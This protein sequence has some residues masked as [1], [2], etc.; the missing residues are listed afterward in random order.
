MQRITKFKRFLHLRPPYWIRH[1]EFWSFEFRFVII[2]L[3]NLDI[4]IF[5][6]KYFLAILGTFWR[7]LSANEGVKHNRLFSPFTKY[8]SSLLVSY[9]VV[10]FSSTSFI[11]CPRIGSNFCSYVKFCSRLRRFDDGLLAKACKIILPSLWAILAAFSCSG[12]RLKVSAT[13]LFLPGLC[14]IEIS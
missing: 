14:S 4:R 6:T 9:F 5:K 13:K 2:T 10:S 3:E 1:F 7:N 12:R 11:F 8:K